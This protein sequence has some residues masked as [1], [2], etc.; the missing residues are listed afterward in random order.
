MKRLFGLMEVLFNIIYLATA[1]IIGFILIFSANGNSPRMLAGIMALVLAGGD[2]FH[3]IPRILVIITGQQEELRGLLGRGKQITSI[4]MTLFYLLLWHV[5]VNFISNKF[6]NSCSILIYTLAIIRIFLCLL[7]QNRW[8]EYN[9][10]NNWAI[11]R[12]IP[13][14]L[15]G[16]LVAYLFFLLKNELEALTF[17]WLAIVLSFAF[18]LPVVLWVDENP[19]IG[20]LML[21]KTLTY[22]WMLFMCLSL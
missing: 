18:Y 20:M 13:F 19:K 4:T 15:Q 16:M 8:T 5:G 7:P 21:P 11:W 10:D 3:L 17:M 9:P 12:N 6:I 1:L 14:L 22:L 2:A